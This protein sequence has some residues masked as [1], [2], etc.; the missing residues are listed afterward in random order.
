[1]ANF[2]GNLSVITKNMGKLGGAM[3]YYHK[4]LDMHIKFGY[5]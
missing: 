4:A 3:E 2:L 1:M 5:E